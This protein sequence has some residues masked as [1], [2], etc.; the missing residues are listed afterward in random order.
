VV[1]VISGKSQSSFSSQID[2]RNGA[3][4]LIGGADP[5][6][7]VGLEVEA[8]DVNGDGKED[9]LIGAPYA[10][11]N[12]LKD[13]S[14]AAYVV[15]GKT[16]FSSNVDLRGGANVVIEGANGGDRL[17]SCI[18]VGNINGDSYND[19][20]LGAPWSDGPNNGLDNSGEA[21]I[22][23]GSPTLS[24]SIDLENNAQDV[25]IYGKN[26]NDVFGLS[27]T[28]GNIDDDGHDDLLIGA[29]NG[30]GQYDQKSNCGETYLIM[31]NSTSNLGSSIDVFLKSRT[32]FYGGSEDDASG[33]SLGTCDLD[34][35][36]FDDIILS[37]PRGDGPNENR[38]NA[39]EFYLIFSRPPP[40]ENLDFEL[41]DGDI[42]G[43]TILSKYKTYTFKVNV[44]NILG[45]KDVKS[46]AITFD[47]I[48]YN[49]KY[50][51]IRASVVQN[52]KFTRVSDPLGMVECLST[53]S[54]AIH[55][56]Q[57]LY[58]INFK[59]KFNWSFNKTYP[60]D[61][62]VSSVG[63]KSL[64][65]EDVYP[66]VFRVNNKLNFEGDLK[67]IG[68]IQG[69]V[70][71]N[72]WV[73]GGEILS[74]TGLTVIYDGAKNY[75]PPKAEFSVGLED[76]TN[77]SI[78]SNPDP[79]IEINGDINTP[80]LT[81]DY[82]YR[83][84]FF[85]IPAYSD[86]SSIKIELKID[87][88]PPNPP[89]FVICK[90]DDLSEPEAA[91]VDDDTEI[92]MTWDP[93]VDKGSG[94]SGYYINFQ[95]NGETENGFW[96]T[97]TASKLANG[98][99]GVN[100]VYVW[101]KDN[102]GNIGSSISS[103]IFIDL[104]EVTF[105][106]FTPISAEKRWFN[107]NDIN[108]TLQVKDQNG[109]GVDPDNI[110]W[111][112][113]QSNRW[114]K[115]KDFEPDG[116]TG[117]TITV[118]PELNEGTESFIKFRAMDLAGN[119]PSESV[120]YYFK[121]D[122]TP[123]EFVSPKPSPEQKLARNIVKCSITIQDLVGSGVNL[124]TIQY[125]YT[126]AGVEE[127]NDWSDAGL[128]ML[129]GSNS[130]SGNG[131]PEVSSTW[132]K[133]LKFKRT[134]ENYIQWR[135]KDLA[136]NGWTV[137]ES[138]RV[139]INA[140][141][142]IIVQEIS[143]NKKLYSNKGVTLDADQ[144]YDDDDHISDLKFSWSSDI[145]GDLGTDR[146]IKAKLPAG[147]H[148]ITINVFDGLN[149]ASYK[150]NITVLD[151]EDAGKGSGLIGFGVIFD[152]LIIL[153]IIICIV[154]SLFFVLYRRERK[155]RQDLEE[156]EQA[157]AYA[158]AQ[159]GPDITY[160]PPYQRQFPAGG[161]LPFS[162]PTIDATITSAQGIS[163]TGRT[164]G[165]QLT[166]AGVIPGQ[167]AQPG[168]GVATQMPQLPGTVGGIGVSSTQGQATGPRA[169]R[170]PR[171][172]VPQ[173]P[174]AQS[175]LQSPSPSM[176]RAGTGTADLGFEIEMLN[177]DPSKKLELLEQKMLLGQISVE[178]YTKLSQ[179]F[180]SELKAKQNHSV[181]ASPTPGSSTKPVPEIY[182]PSQTTS[183]GI[184][185]KQQ[186]S[187]QPRAGSQGQ[188]QAKPQ[189]QPKIQTKVQPQGQ[190]QEQPPLPLKPTS[191]TPQTPMPRS[192]V[193][194]DTTPQIKE[195]KDEKKS[196]TG[197]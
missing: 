119:G 147:Q 173:L 195:K 47:P 50:N 124:T 177:L 70:T 184:T 84:K 135:A 109:F 170:T 187:S 48:G 139:N 188:P 97:E 75:F 45:Y 6:G 190:Q 169:P 137:S 164:S 160:I 60:I 96:T 144:T 79:G 132:L 46:V 127:F 174:P 121:I 31:G 90:A 44:T 134:G 142:T 56:S 51:W 112:S 52:N 8:G 146:I 22:I 197:T 126:T 92:V 4:L 80:K 157:R 74:F 186:V 138:F 65:D 21:V 156:R 33:L 61:C 181:S 16:S 114:V 153:I 71:D 196:E 36:G 27:I 179:K 69:E 64:L 2:L 192:V 7:F 1:W 55:D 110:W 150:F 102:V 95:D 143:E 32:I 63:K 62:I 117:Y 26:S 178:L 37:A 130:D 72:S 40:I 30:D 193:Q 91:L 93:S 108:C 81:V 77:L 67:V 23:Y 116:P 87:N 103:E 168:S 125:R 171:V 5:Y 151:P 85:D 113:I 39:G 182:I 105:E 13:D 180:E 49:I 189:V 106:N 88:D 155:K 120:E 128:A 24:S 133:D 78:I 165:E 42:D 185:P 123:V 141:P 29:V 58:T 100:N 104:T 57:Y 161:S 176:G 131:N 12:A 82:K 122:T 101:A 18:A 86:N 162:G 183:P 28:L 118:T 149:N 59:F 172:P 145:T 34:S 194:P 111:W 41:V 53:T 167:P 10:D 68:S 20:I 129:V 14:G 115:V 89:D 154:L 148:M 140:L 98:T 94:V 38:F 11:F 15:Y 54:D 25:I 163:A 9:I 73:A 191:A 166:G 19:L 175:Q 3:D 17:G 76:N 152:Y 159:G 136:G 43:K 83:V 107:K 158:A 66:D 99:E 35:D